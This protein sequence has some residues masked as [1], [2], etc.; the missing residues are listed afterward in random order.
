M[1]AANIAQNMHDPDKKQC[2]KS[3]LQFSIIF[4]YHTSLLE[5]LWHKGLLIKITMKLGSI[6]KATLQKCNKLKSID[7][8]NPL[9]QINIRFV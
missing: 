5:W 3:H 9:K 8:C 6:F 2:A 7:T 4:V 1:Q